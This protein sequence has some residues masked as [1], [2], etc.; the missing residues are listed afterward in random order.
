MP[1]ANYRPQD[2]GIHPASMSQSKATALFVD[3][4]GVD[5]VLLSSASLSQGA[6]CAFVHNFCRLMQP[7]LL[8]CQG[9]AAGFGTQ[10]PG[11]TA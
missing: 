9:G 11:T 3:A 8:M 4:S 10:L 1:A 5:G 2:L 6:L 7:C